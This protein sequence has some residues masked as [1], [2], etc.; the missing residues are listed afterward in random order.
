MLNLPKHRPKR[1]EIAG[2]AMQ[3]RSLACNNCSPLRAVT[4]DYEVHRV[5]MGQS[6]GILG[7]S[8]QVLVVEDD[9]SERF[10][11]AEMVRRSASVAT[12]ADGREALKGWLSP[13]KVILTD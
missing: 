6:E 13:A 10:D 5:K 7:M 3:D 1:F 9:P 8:A 12:A 2:P 4:F 11:L